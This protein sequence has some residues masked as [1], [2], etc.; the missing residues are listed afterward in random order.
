MNWTDD[1][2]SDEHGPWTHE[3]LMIAAGNAARRKALRRKTTEGD[4]DV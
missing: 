2:Y 4:D 3:E 1:A